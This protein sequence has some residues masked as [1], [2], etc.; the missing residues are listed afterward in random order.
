MY[1]FNRSFESNGV[2]LSPS[3]KDLKLRVGFTPLR[4]MR[5]AVSGENLTD[6]KFLPRFTSTYHAGRRVVATT[7]FRF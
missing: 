1:G 5:V 4:W 3:T 7:E 2:A 6:E